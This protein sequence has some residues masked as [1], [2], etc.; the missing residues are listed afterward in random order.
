[1]AKKEAFSASANLQETNRGTQ[2]TGNGQNRPQ[3]ELET[4]GTILVREAMGH[5]S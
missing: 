1:M 4:M 2:A 5:S 3:Q